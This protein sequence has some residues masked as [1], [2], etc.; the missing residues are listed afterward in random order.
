VRAFFPVDGGTAE[1]PVTGSLNA[2]LAQWLLDSGRVD[3]PYVAAQGT[4]RHREGLLHVDR[5]AD[6]TVWVAGTSR[7]VISGT[8]D[9]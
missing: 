7:T 1:D 8:I 6:G 5:D 2:S 9:A 4:R 3:A